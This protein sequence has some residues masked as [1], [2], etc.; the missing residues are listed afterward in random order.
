MIMLVKD[1]NTLLAEHP[2]RAKL[3]YNFIDVP[4]TMEAVIE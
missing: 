1:V 2:G 3:N 4:M